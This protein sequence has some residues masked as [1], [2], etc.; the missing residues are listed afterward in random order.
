MLRIG[1]LAD[2]HDDVENPYLAIE[3]RKCED[4]DTYIRSLRVF[5]MPVAR[6]DAITNV[7]LAGTEIAKMANSAIQR[8]KNLI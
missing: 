3:R 7:G 5:R 4:G 1:I 2:I 8:P 6:R